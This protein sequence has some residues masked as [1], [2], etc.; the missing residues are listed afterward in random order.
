MH[1]VRGNDALTPLVT[2][3]YLA[4]ITPELRDPS[5][6]PALRSMWLNTWDSPLLNALNIRYFAFPTI[7][8]S[9][10][11][12]KLV[13]V[14]TAGGVHIFG[15]PS[16]LGRAFLVNEWSSV[17]SEGESIEKLKSEAFD[18]SRTACVFGGDLPDPDGAGT[19]TVSIRNYE[20][21]RV[22]IE[23]VTDGNS[24]LVLSDTYFP[25]WKATVNGEKRDLRRVN[26]MMRGVFLESGTNRIQFSYQ[27]VSWR[28]GLFLTMLGCACLS[29]GS[30]IR[31]R[32]GQIGGAGDRS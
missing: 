7:E 31:P 12:A 13:P 2:E 11:P 5:S 9:E 32:S 8:L 3:D 29:G 23:T 26:H 17:G 21:H 30:L 15:N 6:L 14:K 1:D 16:C 20:A 24:L 27:P 10:I 18:P 22:D 4:C 25:G 28:L 19:G